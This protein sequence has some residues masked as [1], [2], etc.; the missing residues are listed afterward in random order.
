MGKPR[1]NK[2][3]KVKKNDDKEVAYKIEIPENNLSKATSLEVSGENVEPISALFVTAS[4]ENG[5]KLFKKCGTCHNYQIN[6]KDDNQYS[7][8]QKDAPNLLTY[9]FDKSPSTMSIS[10]SGLVLWQPLEAD[11]GIHQIIINVNDGLVDVK[12][13]YSLLVKG[14]PT[15]TVADSLSVSVG[16]TL[17]LQ[18]TH[19]NFI[20]HPFKYV[21]K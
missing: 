16:D 19:K 13:E 6:S 12:Q 7:P 8:S 15:I 21:Y 20:I 9:S 18:F 4:I 17:Q 10:D 11:E 1:A 14:P 3:V 5:E 2:F